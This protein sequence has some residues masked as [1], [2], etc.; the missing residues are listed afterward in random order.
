MNQSPSNWA[1]TVPPAGRL[2][3][4]AAVGGWAEE[5]GWPHDEARKTKAIATRAQGRG[6]APRESQ[7]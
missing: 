1:G 6:I 5:A 7:P 3:G 4:A 2:G